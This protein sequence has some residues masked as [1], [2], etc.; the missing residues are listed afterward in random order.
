METARPVLRLA[1]GTRLVGSFEEAVGTQLVLADS[2]AP[3]GSHA[4][5]LVAH[6]DRRIAFAPEP[7]PEAAGDGNAAGGDAAGGDA[8]GGDA[9]GGDAAGGS[10][11]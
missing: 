11:T 9:A 5:Q 8:A 4:V 7:Q 1:D 3:N 10:G 6:T 2:L